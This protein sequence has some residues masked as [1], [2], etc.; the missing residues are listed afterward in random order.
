[1]SVM[2]V[3]PRRTK[4][5]PVGDDVRVGVGPGLFDRPDEVH[6]SVSFTWDLRAARALAYQWER[7]APVKI[8]GPATGMRGENFEP[9]RYVREGYTI[10][11]RGC[12]N[13]CRFCSVWRRE[14]DVRELPIRDGWNVLDDNLL[15]C[16]RGH[17][18]RVFEMLAR[19]QRR[20]EFTGGLEARRLETWHAKA[21]RDVRA[22]QVF[23]AYDTEAALAP[24][25]D[26]VRMLVE[27]G[28]SLKR[29]KIRCYVLCGFEG[30]T[31]DAAERRIQFALDA[32][33][34]PQAMVWRGDD[35]ARSPEWAHW[36]R[37]RSRPAIMH[38]AQVADAGLTP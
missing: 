4:A 11:S 17:I 10:T 35:G 16:S 38:A 5:T 24:L 12:P 21:L 6:V 37:T 8:G 9:G 27:A 30:D 19:Q 3:F 23:F 18:E 7:V 28:F 26:A 13:R 2:R 20:P 34:T 31:I 29:H 36:Q 15:A 32:G 14:G 33:A 22:E 1:M 25:R